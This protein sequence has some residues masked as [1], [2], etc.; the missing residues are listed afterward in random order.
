MQLTTDHRLKNN[1]RPVRPCA[2]ICDL[3]LEDI[4]GHG[5]AGLSDGLLLVI[6]CDNCESICWFSTSS[7]LHLPWLLIL[8]WAPYPL[9]NFC[10]ANHPRFSRSFEATRMKSSKPL[11]VL[12]IF[13][14]VLEYT[15]S[16]SSQFIISIKFNKTPFIFGD[17]K[18]SY[19]LSSHQFSIFVK[20]RFTT[21]NDKTRADTIPISDPKREK[22][23]RF[24]C[25]KG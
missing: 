18:K 24:V 19:L 4:K 2:L 7:L 11:R 15:C 16:P 1:L 22:G 17:S 5:W 13:H 20:I 21:S 14:S 25:W 8:H 6:Y 12:C 3:D 10:E 9:S 23:A